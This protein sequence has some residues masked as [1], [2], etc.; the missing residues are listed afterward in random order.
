M[1]IVILKHLIA[2]LFYKYVMFSI[3]NVLLILMML[4]K[5]PI[6]L[7]IVVEL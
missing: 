7:V 4:I 6:Y 1:P 5:P 2:V 3:Y